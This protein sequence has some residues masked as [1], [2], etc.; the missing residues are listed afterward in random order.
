MSFRFENLEIWQLSR[1][2]AGEIYRK[3]KN[4]PKEEIFG[5]VSQLR[6]A[7]I[8]IVLNI[9]EGSDRKSDMEFIRFL[10]ISVASLD[11]VIAALYI[12]LDQEFM[13]KDDFDALYAEANMLAAKINALVNSIKK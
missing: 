2:F 7:A 6:R 1:S 13:M 3:T 12:A 9:A 4:F 5:L 10:R 8:S 11:E